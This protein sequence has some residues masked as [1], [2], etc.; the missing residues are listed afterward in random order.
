MVHILT[1]LH[2]DIQAILL[3]YVFLNHLACMYNLLPV[4]KQDPIYGAA[5]RTALC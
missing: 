1:R 4:E 2:K 5:C 3:K